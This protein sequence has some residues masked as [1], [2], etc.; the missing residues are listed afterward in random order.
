MRSNAFPLAHNRLD[1]PVEGDD[2]RLDA[3]LFHEF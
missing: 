1:M 2:L 3:N